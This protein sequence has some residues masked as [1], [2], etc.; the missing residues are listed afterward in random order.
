PKKMK[1]E[2]YYPLQ[3][4]V[5]D[6][7]DFI[8][9]YDKKGTVFFFDR[10]GDLRFDA[11]KLKEELIAPLQFSAAGKASEMIGA[12][13]KGNV[14]KINFSGNVKE[15]KF[16]E[17]HSY[18]DFRFIDL[19]DDGKPEYIFIGAEKLVAYNDSFDVVHEINFTLPIDYAAFKPDRK[20]KS[21]YV[22][23][24]LSIQ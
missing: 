4:H 9:A 23:G 7:K 20:N 12:D 22:I 14:Y 17:Q 11:V 1:H 13:S 24:L 16:G 18:F 15:M 21:P 5:E 19:K 2:V 10:K 8:I 3:H 6:G